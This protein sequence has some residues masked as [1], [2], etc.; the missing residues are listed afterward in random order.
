MIR[1][2]AL[3]G[4]LI[5]AGLIAWAGERTPSPAPAN[6]PASEFSAARAMADIAGLASVPHPV[7]SPANRAARDY[8]VRRMTAMGLS[9]QVRPGAGVDVPRFAP[10]ILIGGYVE[11]VV[12]VL[13]GRDRSLP[14]LAL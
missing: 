11:N 3:V 9:P 2:L 10:N 7:G 5:A 13:P 1:L 8:L 4:A 6:A 14:A 12:G